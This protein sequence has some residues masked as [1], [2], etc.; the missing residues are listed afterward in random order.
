MTIIRLDMYFDEE[1]YA[2][3]YPDLSE[4]ELITMFKEDFIDTVQKQWDDEEFKEAL[5]VVAE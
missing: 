3:M 1:E 5:E 2:G 4:A